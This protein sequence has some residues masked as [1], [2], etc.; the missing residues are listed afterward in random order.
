MIY[1]FIDSGL[2]GRHT[3]LLVRFVKQLIAGEDRA[4]AIRRAQRSNKRGIFTILNNLGEDTLEKSAVEATVR[5]YTALVADIGRTKINGC[6]SLKPTQFGICF[7]KDYCYTNM[8]KVMLEAKKNDLFMWVDM[9]SREHTDNTIDIYLK[10]REEY[11]ETGVCIQCYMKRS[12]KDLA[13]LL[14]H[15]AKIRLVKGAYN[16]PPDI[17]FKN[18]DDINREFS[19]QMLML[20]EKGE[21][22]AIATHDSKLIDEAIRLNKKYRR[23]FEFQFL[24]G[25]RDELKARLLDNGFRVTEYVPYGKNWLP[26]TMRRFREKKSNIF[27]LARSM[28]SQS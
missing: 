2:G 20:F 3:A 13:M 19:A 16:E 17:V 1:G 14:S 15:N 28:V 5:E 23:E 26:Y 21:W 6:V 18:M 11:V 25:V 27:L 24:L 8:R 7:D 10:L 4:S 22:F 12:R 9:E